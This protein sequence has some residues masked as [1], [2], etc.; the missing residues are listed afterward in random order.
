MTDEIRTRIESELEVKTYLQNLKFALNNGAKI[1]FQVKRYVDTNRDERY[2]NQ[3][4]VNMLFPDE[5]PVNALK[6]EIQKLTVEEIQ[7]SLKNENPQEGG[8][9]FLRP[10]HSKEAAAWLLRNSE[11]HRLTATL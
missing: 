9:S 2:T 10:F 8:G 11:T 6:R 1:N 7:N 5:N 3:Y 4:T